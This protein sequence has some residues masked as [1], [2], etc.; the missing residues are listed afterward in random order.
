MHSRYSMASQ[1]KTNFSIIGSKP[2]NLTHPYRMRV[3]RSVKLKQLRKAASILIV[4]ILRLGY[5]EHSLV[6]YLD[7]RHVEDELRLLEV[8]EVM[9]C[10]LLCMLEALEGVFCL[11]EV[12]EVICCVLLC[13]LDAVEGVRCILGMLE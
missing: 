3:R 13:M 12:M 7:D 2:Y 8:L 11:L 1:S 9:R 5:L 10:V 4:A 6:A